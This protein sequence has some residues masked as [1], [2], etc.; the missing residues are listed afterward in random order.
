MRPFLPLLA[1]QTMYVATTDNKTSSKKECGIGD[2]YTLT[3]T[4]MTKH[5]LWVVYCCLSDSLL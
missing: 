1:K 5:I 2:I 4:V 3:V